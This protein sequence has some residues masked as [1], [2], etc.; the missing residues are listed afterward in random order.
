MAADFTAY[1]QENATRFEE[2]LPP[3]SSSWS[4]TFQTV[5]ASGTRRAK[6]RTD[7][8]D[9]SD[10]E[11]LCVTI[12]LGANHQSEAVG[13]LMSARGRR[14]SWTQNR[15]RTVSA[16]LFIWRAALATTWK[17]RNSG[18][19]AADRAAMRL[20]CTGERFEC[21]VKT[22]QQQWQTFTGGNCA[23][24]YQE[25]ENEKVC[26][27]KLGCPLFTLR[28]QWSPLIECVQHSTTVR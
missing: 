8:I 7:E 28:N 4:V 2:A 26:V 18:R 13:G 11:G 21:R 17:H 6:K 23:G 25:K 14:S 27:I 12:N 16:L 3:L 10:K 5:R 19:W 15:G 1:Y 22:T 9:F 20:R 24:G